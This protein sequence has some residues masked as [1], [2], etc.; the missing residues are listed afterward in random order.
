MMRSTIPLNN[1]AAAACGSRSYPHRA[2]TLVELLVVVS[3][4]SLLLALLLP[5]L[6][7]AREQAMRVKCAT[8]IRQ[9]YVAFTSY[10]LEAKRLPQAIAPANDG[11]PPA[12]WAWERR[13]TELEYIST[14]Q[15]YGC[16]S[17]RYPRSGSW[18]NTAVRTYRL[19]Q[20]VF[21]ADQT[22]YST[23]NPAG[24]IYGRWGDSVRL[25][26]EVATLHERPNKFMGY[27]SQASVAGWSVDARTTADGENHP[28]T[29]HGDGANYLWGDG[30][31]TYFDFT[32]PGLTP[33]ASSLQFGA[34][35]M[36]TDPD[37]YGSDS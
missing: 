34:N 18:A 1:E 14:D 27:N 15:L 24:C 32:V 23:A 25:P 36:K 10:E 37:K 17:D 5:A 11:G 19:N 35:Y 9:I 21:D 4:I 28:N 31:I 30:Q 2:F 20:Y 26:N 16:P 33:E 7:K 12:H 29:P 22:V 3:I 8:Q 13:L 6:S